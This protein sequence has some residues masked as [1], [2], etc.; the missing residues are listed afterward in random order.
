M[1]ILVF[2]DSHSSLWFMRQCVRLL[3]P[4]CLIHLGDYAEDGSVIHDE[5]PDILFYQVPGNCDGFYGG[6]PEDFTKICES[7]NN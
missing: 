4:D 6:H 7:L 3:K 2:S 5:N 1:K